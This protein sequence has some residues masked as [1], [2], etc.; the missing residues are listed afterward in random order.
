MAKQIYRELTKQNEWQ[1]NPSLGLE[2]W[3][4][5]DATWLPIEG[6]NDWIDDRGGSTPEEA[7]AALAKALNL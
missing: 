3:V 2:S 1:G 4:N 5:I 6:R 7:I